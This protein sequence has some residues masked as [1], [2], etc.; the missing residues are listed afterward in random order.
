MNRKQKERAEKEK[1][2]EEEEAT[3]ASKQDNS[4]IYCNLALLFTDPHEYIH[5]LKLLLVYIHKYSNLIF[6]FCRYRRLT[7]RRSHR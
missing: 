1:L 6:I 5:I 7:N 2:R 3:K 4:G